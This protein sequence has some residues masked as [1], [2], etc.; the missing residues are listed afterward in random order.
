LGVV[1]WQGP[2]HVKPVPDLADLRWHISEGN[3]S[4]GT[5]QRRVEFVNDKAVRYGDRTYNQT[6][7]G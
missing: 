2:W 1:R 6:A 3:M 7:G 5:Y 4:E